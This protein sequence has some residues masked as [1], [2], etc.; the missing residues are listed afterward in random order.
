MVVSVKWIILAFDLWWFEYLCSFIVKL[1]HTFRNLRSW[2]ISVL[3]FRSYIILFINSLQRTISFNNKFLWSLYSNLLLWCFLLFNN[4]QNAVIAFV[5]IVR[6][7]NLALLILKSSCRFNV[8][9][10]TQHELILFWLRRA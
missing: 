10:L 6:D 5:L 4:V 7:Q 3:L 2:N 9:I 8:I 1:W